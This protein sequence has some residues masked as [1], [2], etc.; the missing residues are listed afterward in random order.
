MRRVT[1]EMNGAGGVTEPGIPELRE[2]GPDF[3]GYLATMLHWWWL[4]L[5][6]PLGLGALFLLPREEA[7]APTPIYRTES[8]I[9]IQRVSSSG[10]VA[11]DDLY[12]SQQLA[13]IYREMVTERAVLTDVARELELAVRVMLKAA[14]LRAMAFIMSSLGTR[15]GVSAWRTG[16]LKAHP[17]PPTTAKAKICHTWTQPMAIS[18]AKSRPVTAR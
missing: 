7:Q 11:F 12:S 17:N 2:A 13:L 8:R 18:M 9:L 1:G 16:R 14:E 15:L 5:L 3:R 10:T 6:L 4:F